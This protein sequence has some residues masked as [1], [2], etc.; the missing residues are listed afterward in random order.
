MKYLSLFMLSLSIS[1]MI[2]CD[3]S[4]NSDIEEKDFIPLTVGNKYFL[5]FFLS[6]TTTNR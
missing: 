1:L 2:S 5:L 4:L 3:D 6:F